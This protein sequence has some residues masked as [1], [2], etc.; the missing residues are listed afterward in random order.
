[1]YVA[2]G[3]SITMFTG[4][5]SIKMRIGLRVFLLIVL[6]MSMIHTLAFSQE[7]RVYPD[8]SA[9]L[10]NERAG[11]FRP[12]RAGSPVVS[13][14]D[15]NITWQ[16][17]TLI[18]SLPPV[19]LFINDIIQ[20]TNALHLFI[21]ATSSE[22]GLVHQRSFDDGVTWEEPDQIIPS[23]A[24]NGSASIAVVGD[25]IFVDRLDSSDPPG[26][27]TIKIIR[28]IDDGDTWENEIVLH[29]SD[30]A[31]LPAIAASDSII[32]AI[33][34]DRVAVL[35]DSLF[36]TR[37]IDG[38][39][40]WSTPYPFPPSQ[41]IRVRPK[42]AAADSVIHLVWVGDLLTFGSDIHYMRSSDYGVTWNEPFLL[43]IND[44]LLGQV[45]ALDTGDDGAVYAVWMDYRFAPGGFTGD[46][47]FRKSRNGGVTWD[48]IQILT[49]IPDATFPQ[50]SIYGDI[51]DVVWQDQR[52]GGDH[53]SEIF[54]KRSV[55]GGIT[56]CDEEQLTD[57]LNGRFF[58][59]V[60][61]EIDM[62]HTAWS[63]TRETAGELFRRDIYYK[64]GQF[65]PV[66]VHDSLNNLPLRTIL[67]QNYPNPFNPE[68]T[69]R[70]ALTEGGHTSVIV[71]DLSGREITRLVDGFMS[72]GDH[73][74]TWNAIDASS[75][76]YL[77]RIRSGEFDK[78]IKMLLIK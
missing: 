73:K 10:R 44:S 39:D 49:D 66:N 28:S 4:H 37:S 78:T 31:S 19:S 51:V 40:T 8:G 61:T 21:K 22:G 23:S 26:M 74:V 54:H 58:P 65:E 34:Q 35:T 12:E 55:D 75:G 7:K 20:T 29:R 77:Y 60:L 6:L 46:I 50:I 1:M 16:A 53:D 70:F 5:C 43:G 57:E 47:F 25:T 32:Y 42:L 67:R 64:K 69:I 2:F 63:D 68:T 41:T 3:A 15:C 11:T 24:I 27:G 18:A 71:Y 62:V 17:D 52:E 45:P 38:G 36:L 9:V 76:I 59:Y 13:F 30:M 33:F 14:S 56:W 72:G 48:D